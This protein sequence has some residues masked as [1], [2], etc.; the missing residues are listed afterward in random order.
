[1][2]KRSAKELADL[3][4]YSIRPA[5][6]EAHLITGKQAGDQVYATTLAEELRDIERTIAALESDLHLAPAG[7]GRQLPGERPSAKWIRSKS[8]EL[9]VRLRRVEKSCEGENP[10]GFTRLAS[11]ALIR[12]AINPCPDRPNRPARSDI[13]PT[14]L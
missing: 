10:S 2:A 13:P 12:A 1:M 7:D 9:E 3:I 5:L 14:A 11:R 6:A 4:L 8:A